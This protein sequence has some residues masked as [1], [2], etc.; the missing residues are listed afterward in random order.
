MST[1]KSRSPWLSEEN[2][3]ASVPGK[4]KKTIRH[5]ASRQSRFGMRQQETCRRMTPANRNPPAFFEG[6][7]PDNV[8][9]ELG[10]SDKLPHWA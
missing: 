8:T 4:H 9:C 3:N 10:T 6:Y 5:K 1:P 2:E 7:W